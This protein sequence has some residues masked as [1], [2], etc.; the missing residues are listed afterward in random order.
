MV[1]RRVTFKFK[2]EKKITMNFV[3]VMAIYISDAHLLKDEPGVLHVLLTENQNH[4][5]TQHCRAQQTLLQ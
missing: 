4:S 1:F 2:G 3:L 5:F